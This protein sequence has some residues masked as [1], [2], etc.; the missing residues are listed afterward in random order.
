MI[1]QPLVSCICIT[2]NRVELLRRAINCFK[3]QSYFN[4]EL[5][6]LYESDDLET[7]EY[8]KCLE[9]S[10]IQIVEVNPNLR[11]T[12]GELRNL[13]IKSSKGEYFCQWDDDDWY[14]IRRLEFQMNASRYS[15]KPVCLLA[16]WL[17]FDGLKNQAYLSLP[18]LWEGSILCKKNILGDQL[19]YANLPR[20]EDT[21]FRNALIPK[22]VIY[23][24]LMP[25]LYIYNYTGRNTWDYDH[26][27]SLFDESQN[28]PA[29][30]SQLIKDILD[31]KY[32]VKE[33]SSMLDSP[34]VLQ[35]FNYLKNFRYDARF[36]TFPDLF[37]LIS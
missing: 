17:L 20:G 21:I 3:G 8:L 14:H 6:I 2:R 28:L 35:E 30:V 36:N 24:L 13:G 22:N 25:N 18:S 9:D 7:G 31:Q 4:K 26:F 37:E 10:K 32:D 27:K 11:L 33:S 16:Y 34:D 12:L 19:K 29:N 23:P 5:V 15:Q 1:D